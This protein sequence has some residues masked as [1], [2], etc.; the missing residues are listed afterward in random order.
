[1]F[2]QES[3][4]SVTG[5][6]RRVQYIT[7]LSQVP[8]IPEEERKRL[9]SVAGRYAFRVNDYYLSLIDWDDP[10]DPIRQL[11]IP[12]TGELEEWGILDASSESAVTVARGVQHKYASTALLLV[13][14]ACASYCRYCFRKR[15]F[16]PGS[17]ETSTDVSEGLEYIASNPEVKDVLLTGGDPLMLSTDRLISIIEELRAIPHVNLIRIGSKM[18]AFN[19]WRILDDKPLVDALRDLST[20]ETRT[21]LMAHF[22]HPRELTDV[23]EAALDS[24]INA[25]VV[26]LNQCPLVR[27]INSDPEVL[28]ELFQ[29]LAAIGCAPYYIFQV[30]PTSGNAPYAVPIVENLGILDEVGKRL[31]GLAQRARYV[32]SHAT[33]KIEVL[34]ADSDYIYMRYHRAMN[35]ANHGRFLAYYR[36]ESAYWLEDLEPVHELGVPAVV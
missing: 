33:G 28:S 23:A 17:S 6:T 10:N 5:S 9:E 14:N 8:E 3:Q 34:G 32:M 30:R 29:K 18:P 22:D 24:L 15:F 20:T 35:P 1:M 4:K 13:T 21:Y 2:S 26:C 19:P 12:Q 31:S 16:I 11:V 25:G 27:G 7:D 36:N